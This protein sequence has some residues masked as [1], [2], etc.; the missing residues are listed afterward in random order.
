MFPL[1]GFPPCKNSVCSGPE[2]CAA[3]MFPPELVGKDGE[4][5]KMTIEKENPN[6]TAIIMSIGIVKINFCCNKVYIFIDS[7]HN[8]VSVPIIG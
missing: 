6:V 7:N 3:G 5:A 2:C 4:I 8:V 1:P